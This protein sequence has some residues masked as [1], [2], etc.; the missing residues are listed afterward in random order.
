MFQTGTGPLTFLMAASVAAAAFLPASPPYV[1]R[2]KSLHTCAGLAQFGHPAT[3]T[4]SHPAYRAV[5][6]MSLPRI[7][8]TLKNEHKL[9]LVSIQGAC[10]YH[11]DKL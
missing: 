4:A 2:Q 5:S 6:T 10:T 3:L 9:A 7:F 11:R 8:D 1:L